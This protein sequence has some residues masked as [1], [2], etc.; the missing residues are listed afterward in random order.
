ME[1]LSTMELLQ[2]EFV[3]VLLDGRDPS[4]GEIVLEADWPL[5]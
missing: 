2:L 1:V 3:W 4:V 5:G